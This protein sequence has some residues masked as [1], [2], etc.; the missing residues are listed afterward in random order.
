VCGIHRQGK[1]P[2]AA[3]GEIA[4]TVQRMLEQRQSGVALR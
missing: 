2:D 3:A 4:R 1:P